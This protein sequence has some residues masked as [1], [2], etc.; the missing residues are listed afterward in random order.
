M[1]RPARKTK[2]INYS[3]VREIDDDDEDFACAKPPPGKKPK[4]AASQETTRKALEEKSLSRDLQAAISLSMLACAETKTASPA[5][6]GDENLNPAY[7]H[8][9][10]CSVDSSLLGLDEISRS[11]PT[12]VKKQ[13]QPACDDVYLPISTTESESEEEARSEDEEFTVKKTQQK[14]VSRHQRKPNKKEREPP[15]LKAQPKT[16]S[17]AAAPRSPPRLEPAVSFSPTVGRMPKWN[18]PGSPSWSKREVRQTEAF[19]LLKC[20]LYPAGQVGKNPSPAPG[21]ARSPAAQGLR[22]GLSRRVR[23]KPLHPNSSAT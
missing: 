12:S 19:C 22:L 16:A 7:P 20:L 5:S 3:E 2:S 9:S 17:F 1:D 13:K 4:T 6:Q 8:H 14:K 11:S 15:E 10:N 21:G 18:P 23:V